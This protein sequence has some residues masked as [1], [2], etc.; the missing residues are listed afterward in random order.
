MMKVKPILKKQFCTVYQ[1]LL[2]EG[3]NEGAGVDLLQ[4]QVEGSNEF[5]PAGDIIFRYRESESELN[6]SAIEMNNSKSETSGDPL[7]FLE[8]STD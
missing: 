6:T 5:V 8:D 2:E 3:E 1:G 7:L 4:E